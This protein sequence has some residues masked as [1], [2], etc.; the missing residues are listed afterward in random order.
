MMFG[1][2]SLKIGSIADME[3]SVFEALKNIDKMLRHG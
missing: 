1:N 3:H 2:T